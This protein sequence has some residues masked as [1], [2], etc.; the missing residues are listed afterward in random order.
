LRR[1]DRGAGLPSPSDDG[2]FE[3]FFE[4]DPSCARI[5]AIS[6]RS[7]LMVAVSA[8]TVVCNAVFVAAIAFTNAMS[9][10]R[11]KSSGTCP[12]SLCRRHFHHCHTAIRA[13][14]LSLDP[15]PRFLSG[16]DGV[17]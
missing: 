6:A 4:F 7:S 12:F 3:E 5:A 17:R 14:R 8:S 13:T 15:P 11:D 1:N 10:S 16:A 9:S 2:G